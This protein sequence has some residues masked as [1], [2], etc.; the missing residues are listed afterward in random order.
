MEHTNN[1][2]AAIN[3]HHTLLENRLIGIELQLRNLADQYSGLQDTVDVLEDHNDPY[4]RMSGCEERL[5]QLERSSSSSIDRLWIALNIEVSKREER[6]RKEAIQVA[7]QHHS[8][9]T[10]PGIK[11]AK[12]TPPEEIIIPQMAATMP[13]VQPIPQIPLILNTTASIA[14]S[15]EMPKKIQLSLRQPVSIEQISEPVSESISLTSRPR[16]DIYRGKG[17]FCDHLLTKELIAD[18]P[19]DMIRIVL[20]RARSIATYY[21]TLNSPKYRMSKTNTEAI[22]AELKRREC[23]LLL[24]S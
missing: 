20:N 4:S 12:W 19:N 2:T 13:V 7:S 5:N 14:E 6:E 15:L 11:I 8:R 24:K 21:R 1:I 10:D 18:I 16:R 9:P 22:R 3:S 23:V 17:F